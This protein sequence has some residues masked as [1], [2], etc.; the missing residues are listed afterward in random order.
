MVAGSGHVFGAV[1]ASFCTPGSSQSQ[2]QFLSFLRDSI[3][4]D[5][6]GAA[7]FVFCIGLAQAAVPPSHKNHTLGTPKC[8]FL[9]LALAAVPPSHKNHTLGTPKCVFFALGCGR[10]SPFT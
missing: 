2:Q 8:V 5:A 4:H 6:L 1:D 10:G 7:V 9:R 3:P